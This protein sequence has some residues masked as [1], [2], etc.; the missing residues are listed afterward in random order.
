MLIIR[1]LHLEDV[2]A[3]EE[4]GRVLV[5]VQHHPEEFPT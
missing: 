1:H 4:T 2:T 5:P 3:E